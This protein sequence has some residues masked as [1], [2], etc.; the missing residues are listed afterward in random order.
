MAILH[1]DDEDDNSDDEI[2]V[3]SSVGDGLN[4]GDGGDSGAVEDTGPQL[5]QATIQKLVSQFSA[6]SHALESIHRCIQVVM[7]CLCRGQLFVA[8][9]LTCAHCLQIVFEMSFA[10]AL[11]VSNNSPSASSSKKSSPDNSRT[12]TPDSRRKPRSGS[13][14]SARGLLSPHGSMRSLNRTWSQV[15]GLGTS[16]DDI[17]DVLAGGLVDLVLV[18]D[19][20]APK[21]IWHDW[22][23]NRTVLTAMRCGLQICCG[24]S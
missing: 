13:S 23:S 8:S 12:S 20:E 4:L 17:P 2:V 5:D 22:A 16:N 3:V 24:D 9:T 15:S 21:T 10:S 14:G 11:R 18:L 6:S 19:Q 1:S 7:A